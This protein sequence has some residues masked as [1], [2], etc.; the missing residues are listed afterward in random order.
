[1]PADGADDEDVAD[2]CSV[3]RWTSTVASGPRPLS[4][5]AS[6]TVAFGG[7]VGIGLQLEDFGLELDRLE[8]LVEVGLLER[9]D[10][11]VLDLAAHRPRR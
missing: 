11:D 10:F 3:P 4:S 5:L 7:A 2:A 8:Q 6:T 1:M 9:R